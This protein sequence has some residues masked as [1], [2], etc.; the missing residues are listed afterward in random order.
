MKYTDPYIPKWLSVASLIVGIIFALILLV[1]GWVEAL[2][3]L[4]TL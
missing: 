3:W 4:A 2:E 1:W